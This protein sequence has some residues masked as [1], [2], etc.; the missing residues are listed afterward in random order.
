MRANLANIK[1]DF[2]CALLGAA[3]GVL[4]AILAH[5]RNAWQFS[6]LS[7]AYSASVLLA[8]ALLIGPVRVLRGGTPLRSSHV[9]RHLGFWSG[10]FALG[11]VVAGL[12]VHFDGQMLS[13]FFMPGMEVGFATMRLDAFGAANDIGLLATLTIAFL[14]AISN[15]RSLVNIGIHRWKNLQR[16]TYPLAVIIV[17]HAV[18]YQLLETRYWAFMA[19]NLGLFTLVLMG[20]LTAARRIRSRKA[21]ADLPVAEKDHQCHERPKPDH[22]ALS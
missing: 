1:L 8:A 2:C 16:S 22:A 17:I 15:N 13:Y 11:H 7:L 12:N 18:I 20:Q 21:V 4:P 10:V 14:M 19:L 5:P 6:S 9:R 3:A